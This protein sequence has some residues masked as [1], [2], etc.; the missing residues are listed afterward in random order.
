MERE[1]IATF[2]AATSRPEY[3]TVDKLDAGLGGCDHRSSRSLSEEGDRD[4]FGYHE[5]A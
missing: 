2:R 1:V 3:L 4:G 5:G